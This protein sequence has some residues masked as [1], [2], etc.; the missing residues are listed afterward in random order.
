[1]GKNPNSFAGIDLHIVEIDL[2]L[3]STTFRLFQQEQTELV[4]KHPPSSQ[5][6]AEHT[7][8]DTKQGWQ[9]GQSGVIA[10]EKAFYIP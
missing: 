6:E 9:R 7:E 8:S 10:E 3:I 5:G 2:I 1:M 4:E